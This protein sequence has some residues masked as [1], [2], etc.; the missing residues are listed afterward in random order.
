MM[1]GRIPNYES[2]LY[3]QFEE[4]NKKLDCL[5]KKNKELNNTIKELN[6]Q[7]ENANATIEK[8]QN[9]IDRL[10]NK[11]TKN[12][13]NSSKPSSTNFTTPKKRLVLIEASE[14][15]VKIKLIYKFITSRYQF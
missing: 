13:T 5:L 12:S 11:N 1:M 6:K 10:K 14:K 7:L 15:V 2:G 9:E 3:R 8:L 4:L